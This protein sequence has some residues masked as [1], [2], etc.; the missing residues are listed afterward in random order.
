MLIIHI[1]S[2]I[3]QGNSILLRCDIAVYDLVRQAGKWTA[4]GCQN[5]G[6]KGKVP[7]IMVDQ[8]SLHQ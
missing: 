5:A 7:G 6:G 8:R 3:I 1:I 2:F 4:M